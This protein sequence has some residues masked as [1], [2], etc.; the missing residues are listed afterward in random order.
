M[1]QA[2]VTQAGS[3]LKVEGI[4]N[5]PQ[6]TVFRA[7]TDDTL[8]K[9][10][11]SPDGWETTTSQMDFREGGQWFYIMTC[12]DPESE[13]YG[14][15]SSGLTTYSEIKAPESYQFTDAFTDEAGNINEAMPLLKGS[16]QFE[17]LGT[18]TKVINI[19]ELNSPEEVKQLLDMGMIE[20]LEGTW[21]K[22][23]RLLMTLTD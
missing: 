18:Q 21:R 7:Y 8:L 22:L 5:A 14:Q 19:T 15:T 12:T 20:G 17:S 23:E 10:W 9:Q 16:Y 6:M 3:Q 1:V 4:F 2:K 13:T 11:W